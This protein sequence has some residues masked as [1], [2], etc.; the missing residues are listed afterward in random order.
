MAFSWFRRKQRGGIRTRTDLLNHLIAAKEYHRYLEIGVRD[1]RHNFKQVQLVDK[2]SVDPNPRRPV[3]HQMTSDAYFAKLQAEDPSS[4]YDLVFIDGLHLAE[5][6]EADVTNSL[7]HL[8]DGGSIVLHDC[9]PMTEDAQTEEYDG[10]KHWNG[11]VWKAWVKLRA[12]R[13]DLSM[14]VVDIDEGCGVICR[15]AQTPYQ[16]PTL[17]YDRLS[18]DFLRVNRREALNLV[19]VNAFLNLIGSDRQDAGTKTA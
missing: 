1:P 11:T 10:K 4:K 2:Q 19:S 9:N 14:W 3:T 12:T 16:L 7:Q 6:V 8:S 15:G 18:Y 17:E 5:Q 13:A